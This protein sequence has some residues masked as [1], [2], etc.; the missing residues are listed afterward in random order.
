MHLKLTL[1]R[2]HISNFFYF[3]WPSFSVLCRLEF[4]LFVC[5]SKERCIFLRETSSDEVHLRGVEGVLVFFLLNQDIVDDITSHFLSEINRLLLSWLLLDLLWFILSLLVR[6]ILLLLSI[7]LMEPKV[8]IISSNI[9]VDIHPMVKDDN[10]SWRALRSKF[11]R[12]EE[13]WANSSTSCYT[14]MSDNK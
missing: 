2:L 11:S 12:V 3:I 13:T 7:V 8:L 6:S 1:N 4:N 10:L 9:L 5:P 14:L